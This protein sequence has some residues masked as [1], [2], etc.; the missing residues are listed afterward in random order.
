MTAD[1]KLVRD[2]IPDIIRAK[3][4]E[5]ITYRAD[6]AEYR[7][8]LRDKLAEEVD[9]FLKADDEHAP[10]ELADVLEVVYALAA[11]LGISKAQLEKVR[12]DKA[13]ARG[14]FAE[15]IVWSG[16]R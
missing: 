14:G 4:E 15:R 8:R 13:A 5:P 11:E 10:E 6:A 16:V 7:R 9:E 2:L 3:G 1:G 12:E